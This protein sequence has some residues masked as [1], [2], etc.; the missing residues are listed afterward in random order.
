LALSLSQRISPLSLLT[1][2]CVGSLAA[3]LARRMYGPVMNDAIRP[4]RL[5]I[6]PWGVLVHADAAP[7]V[8]H[9]AAVR[10]VNVEL[11]HEMDHATPSTRWSLITVRTERETF[12]GRAH[13]SVSL[14][15][16]EA[17]LGLYTVEAGRPLALDL[18][19]DVPLGGLLEPTFEPLLSEARRLVASGDLRERLALAP[20]SYRDAGTEACPETQRALKSVLR[21]G[22]ESNADA[23]ALAAVLAVE[24]GAKGLLAEVVPLTLS[25]NPLLAAVSRG[26]ALRLGADI[27]Q[28]GA[29]E[30]IGDFLPELDLLQIREWSQVS[31]RRAA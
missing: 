21:S 9:W 20:R 23:R 26:A 7:R 25:P 14:E 16:L 11:F 3:I 24:L 4:H 2:L 28:V 29:L 22:L 18:D 12:A 13:G 31:A 8:L 27:K 19:G 10:E 30:E 17:H 6:V 1:A 15:R 5:S